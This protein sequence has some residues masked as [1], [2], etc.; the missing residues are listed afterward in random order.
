MDTYIISYI[1]IYLTLFADIVIVSI[2]LLWFLSLLTKRKI[3][4][5]EKIFYYVGKN[6]LLLSFIISV[7]ATLGSLFYSEILGYS[8]CKLCWY[9]RI[10]M[11]PQVLFF[12]I[13]LFK[14]DRSILNYVLPL[15]VIGFFVAG[16][17]YFLQMSKNI[18]FSCEVVGYS[19]ACSEKFLLHLGYITIPMMAFTA[20]ALLILFQF[21]QL[22]GG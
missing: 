12:G 14:K 9:Q 1:L 7:V 16:F 19:A 13:A 20:F 4:I 21:I 5:K 3:L 2:I 15:S 6:F 10:L 11:Y 18:S 22:K 17:H 8:P